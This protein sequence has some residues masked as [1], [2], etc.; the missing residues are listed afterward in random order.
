M[1]LRISPDAT[2]EHRAIDRQ[3]E[4]CEAKAAEKGLLVSGVYIDN[5]I[6]ASK[7]NVVRPAYERMV[8][9]YK[10]GAFTN[11]ICY[12]IDRLSRQ[13]VQIEW[14]LEAAEQGQLLIITETG[15]AD[16]STDSGRLFIRLKVVVAKAEIERKGERQKRAIVQK[17]ERGEPYAGVRLT[18]YSMDGQIIEEEAAVI[19]R[20]FQTFLAGGTLYGIAGELTKAGIKTRRGNANWPT[21]TVRTILTNPRYIS[22]VQHTSLH[23]KTK[24]KI[25]TE[26]AGDWVPIIDDPTFHAVQARLE[27]PLRIT[28]RAGTHRKH[29]GSGLFLCGECG[30]PVRTNGTRYWCKDGGHVLRTQGPIDDLVLGSLRRRLALNDLG[31]AVSQKNDDAATAKLVADSK[32][33]RNDLA[34]YDRDY[35]AGALAAAFHQKLTLKAEAK[36]RAIEAEYAKATSGAAVAMMMG[37]SNPL[38]FF[39]NAGL[40]RRRAIVSSLMT[41]AL[42]HVPRGRKGFDPRTVRIVWSDGRGELSQNADRGDAEPDGHE[43]RAAVDVA[44]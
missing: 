37:A 34:R 16:T 7:R 25:V 33:I 27:D 1:Y 5:S 35:E 22:R 42:L 31:R 13:P 9:D 11:L 23:K 29:L 39:D 38:E 32:A 15:E 10:A 36:L 40:A 24:A 17:L 2:G 41:V 20:I 8:N 18:G 19:R 14:W 4:D 12:D 44:P 6:S 30:Q 3:R 43:T 26:Y 28:N 21:S